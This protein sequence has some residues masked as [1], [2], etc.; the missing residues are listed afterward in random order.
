MSAAKRPYSCDIYIQELN[1]DATLRGEPRRITRQGLSIGEL[2]WSP[3]GS[4]LVY[5]A[6]D[7]LVSGDFFWRVETS[8]SGLPQRLDMAGARVSS[9]A[10]DD[11]GKRLLYSRNLD[12]VDLRSFRE[13][14][15]AEAIAVSTAVESN[16]QFSPDG[17]RIA[18]E[19]NRNGSEEIWLANADGTQPTQLTNRVGRF[20]GTPRW[21]PDG[22]QIAFDSQGQDGRWDIFVIEASGGQ[23]R[24]LTTEPS[25]EF[26]PSWSRDGKW[27]YFCSLRTGREEIWRVP[28]TGGRQERVSIN[29]GHVAFESMDGKNLYY[30]R[31]ASSDAALIVRPVSGG[32]E[33]EVSA[34]H[35]A[36][37]SANGPGNLLRRKVG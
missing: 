22:R 21:S 9:P 17:K 29:G 32:P 23:S 31:S 30:S 34:S 11:S 19:S 13:G 36:V 20:Q 6:G 37:I 5:A 4:S 2:T 26:I 25:D 8:G 18:F 1:P 24:R 7:S 12:D 10:F 28:S 15:G 14:R 35:D 33:T 3:D 27:I 16:P